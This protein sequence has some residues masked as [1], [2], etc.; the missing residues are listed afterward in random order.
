MRNSYDNLICPSLFVA[1]EV[2]HGHRD[3]TQVVMD[4]NRSLKRF[5]PGQNLISL[6]LTPF[7]M[8]YNLKEFSSKFLEQ[9]DRKTTDKYNLLK[10]RENCKQYLQREKTL[11]RMF[12]YREKIHPPL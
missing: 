8:I 11:K 4:V 6:K 1:E 2:L 7:L 3:Y 5:P 9:F 10:R 12:S